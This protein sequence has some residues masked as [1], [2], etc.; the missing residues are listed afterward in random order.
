MLHGQLETLNPDLTRWQG[1]LG[2][3]DHR[4]GHWYSTAAALAY[5]LPCE[6]AIRPRFWRRAVHGTHPRPQ[7]SIAMVRCE[8]FEFE[9]N[10]SRGRN[11]DFTK[12][13]NYAAQDSNPENLRVNE[14]RYA[15]R[16]HYIRAI[17]CSAHVPIF[18]QTYVLCMF[19]VLI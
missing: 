18:P 17:N 12:A 5:R 16:L 11:G 15:A 14:V 9:I 19:T 2:R 13:S 10:E 1:A 7:L 8:W 6:A 4:A 3:G